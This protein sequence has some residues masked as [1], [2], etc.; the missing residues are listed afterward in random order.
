MT[1]F[2]RWQDWTVVLAGILLVVAPYV[3]NETSNSTAL[4]TTGIIGAAMAISGLLSASTRYANAMEFLPA[5]CGIAAF[6]AP[7]VGNFTNLTATSWTSYIV[8]VVAV[9]LA[10]EVSLESRGTPQHV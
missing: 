9:L 1:A 8:G 4:W 2:R 10:G 3:F 7:F 6:F 5:L